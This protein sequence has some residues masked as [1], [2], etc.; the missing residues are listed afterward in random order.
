[1]IEFLDTY[2][3]IINKDKVIIANRDTGAWM[4]ISKECRDILNDTI[5]FSMTGEE[6]FSKFEDEGDQNYFK[7]LLDKLKE[8]EVVSE[9]GVKKN[10]LDVI[11]LLVTNRCNLKCIHCCADAFNEDSEAFKNEMDIDE[12]KRVIDKVADVNPKGVA[13]TGGEPM[14]RSDFFGV[15]KYLRSEYKGEIS[16]ATNAT[17]I[18]EENVGMLIKLVD[19][20]DISVDGIDE[21]SCSKVRGRGVYDK[22]MHSIKLLKAN[23][24]NE[25]SLSMTFGTSNYH[26]RGEFLSLNKK[27]G[28]K[29]I[30]RIFMPKGRGEKSNKLFNSIPQKAPETTFTSEET[31]KVKKS[32][33]SI[34]CGAGTKEFVINYDGW[35]YPCPNM[36][37]DKYKIINIKE[38]ER[39]E[40]IHTLLF[41][42]EREKINNLIKIQPENFER[43]KDCKINL[44]CWSCLA[45]IE[46]KFKDDESFQKRCEFQKKILYPLL[47]K[48]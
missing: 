21:E 16:L 13:I 24:S 26:L 5:H 22:V 12:L 34:R 2:R 18:T 19:K 43:C 42:K 35:I 29:P 36:I 3:E 28:T 7:F 46:L 20:F 44:F 33:Q 15:L 38:V 39:I 41:S 6:L 48:D 40:E 4:K 1:M 30:V 11:Y 10:K 17:L 25:I 23:G 31:E 45:D 27:L 8:L 47:W 37:I 32:L 14:V 9:T